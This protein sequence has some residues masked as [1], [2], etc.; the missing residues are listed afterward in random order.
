MTHELMLKCPV[1]IGKEG[2]LRFWLVDLEGIGTLPP[3]KLKKG[4]TGQ[5]GMNRNVSHSHCSLSSSPALDSLGRSHPCFLTA[6]CRVSRCM[7]LMPFA[8]ANAG[9]KSL[10]VGLTVAN[11]KSAPS[12]WP[13]LQ[14]QEPQFGRLAGEWSAKSRART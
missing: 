9:G 3:K 2:H 5:L 1:T 7:H 10:T 4:T 11:I 14:R 13:A 12:P 8:T 6:I